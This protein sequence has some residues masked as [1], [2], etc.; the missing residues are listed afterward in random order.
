MKARQQSGF[1]L[2]ELVVVIVILGILAATAIPRYAAY[3]SQARIAAL[4]GV[5]GAVNS[6]VL[7][8][9]GRY[10]STGATTSPV[11]MLDGTTVAVLAGTPGPAN[12][13]AG[14]PTAAGIG[15][16]VNLNGSFNVSAAGLFTFPTAVTNC[17]LQYNA[18]TAAANYTLTLTTT[19]C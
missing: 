6:A 11:T 8:V 2:V 3:T 12:V 16:A 9:Q 1:T 19:G 5:Q 14:Q 15:S 10:I 18:P 17:N 7:V 13:G 4:Q